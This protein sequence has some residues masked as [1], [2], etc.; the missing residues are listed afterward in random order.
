LKNRDLFV[1]SKNQPL[2]Y[3][4][5]LKSI[6]SASLDAKGTDILILD[7]E[8][9]STI[10]DHFLIVSGRSDRQVQGIA[11]RIIDQLETL[12]LLPLSVDGLDVGHWVVLDYGF[13]IVHVFYESDRER[14]DLEGYWNRAPRTAVVLTKEGDISLTKSTKAA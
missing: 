6:V 8:G 14:I 4:K 3:R 1:N 10:T 12:N 7:M 9:I 5:I 11:N 2:N 13:I